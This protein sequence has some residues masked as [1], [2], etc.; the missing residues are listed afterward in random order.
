M[1]P[2]SPYQIQRKSFKIVLPQKLVQIN[3][4]QFKH[5]TSVASEYEGVL[6]FDDVVVG[7]W[8]VHEDSFEY[9]DLDFS[10]AVEFRVIFYNFQGHFFFLFVV[11]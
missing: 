9:F 4:Q 1:N 5:Q 2:D 6:E 7:V 10:L 3:V 8:I 11:K